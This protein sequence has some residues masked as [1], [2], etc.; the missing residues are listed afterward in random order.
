MKFDILVDIVGASLELTNNSF[1][2]SW[3]GV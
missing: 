1:R 3:S 2:W